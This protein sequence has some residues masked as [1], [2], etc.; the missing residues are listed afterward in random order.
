MQAERKGFIADQRRIKAM[1]DEIKSRSARVLE[2]IA[3]QD[4]PRQD[5]QVEASRTGSQRVAEHDQEGCAGLG[6]EVRGASLV[7]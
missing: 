7:G 6:Y 5:Q 4:A 3:I 2:R 1:K